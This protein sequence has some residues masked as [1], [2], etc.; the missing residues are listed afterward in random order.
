VEGAAT[1]ADGLRLARARKHDLILLDLILDEDDGLELLQLFRTE[2]NTR[3]VIIVTGVAPDEEITRECER[4][5]AVG[6][7]SK[8]ST[9]DHL[10]MQVQRA[11]RE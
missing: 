9:V 7:V 3:P 4:R 11:L 10:L 5:G 2:D 8:D 1:A 6:F